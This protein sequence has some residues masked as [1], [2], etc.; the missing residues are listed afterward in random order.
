[1]EGNESI[2][3][4]ILAL[5]KAK[6]VTQ[7][8]LGVYLNISYQ[9]V[10][11]W[12]RGES[13]P[14]F[15]TMTRLAEYFGVS[16]NYFAGT[17]EKTESVAEETAGTESVAEETVAEETQLQVEKEPEK[18]MLGICKDCGK[19]VYRGEEWIVEPALI[20]LKCRDRRARIK[21][22]KELEIKRKKEQEERARIEA[23]AFRQEQI[24]RKRNK[25]FIIGG[26]FAGLGVL[27]GLA[28]SILCGFVPDGWIF[29]V[30]GLIFGGFTFTF[31]TQMV[32]G[33]F[34]R[35]CAL[36]G[37][38]IIGTPGIIFTFDLDGFIFLI[39]MKL[40]FA[41]LRF[42]VYI[43]SL[44]FFVVVAVLLSPF[45]FVPALIRVLSGDFTD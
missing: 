8:D 26:I 10:S 12:E 3:A 44:L 29:L 39:G 17:E 16:L 43:L 41:L 28:L 45:T 31:I 20:C 9:A 23:E 19:V 5:R 33:G 18:E 11:K 7:A 42:A 1:M 37:G 15:L 2:G 6:G 13:C 40:L 21:K 24:A 14:D 27:G 36:F 34:V 30:L 35:D 32:W 25:G 22:Q 38:T 4:K